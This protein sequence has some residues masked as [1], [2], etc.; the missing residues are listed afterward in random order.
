ME[1]REH[2]EPQ[3]LMGPQELMDEM[4]HPAQLD[5]LDPRVFQ[6][7]KDLS[8]AWDPQEYPAV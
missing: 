4:E 5:S 6:V 1:T 8:A 7:N 2:R 3:G